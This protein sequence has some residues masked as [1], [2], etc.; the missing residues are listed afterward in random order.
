MDDKH[1]E[2][3]TRKAKKRSR[4]FNSRTF[5]GQSDSLSLPFARVSGE[6][7][8][9]R[10]IDLGRNPRLL[11]SIREI[12]G[13]PSGL[14]YTY[15]FAVTG[16]TIIVIENQCNFVTTPAQS[17][18]FADIIGSSGFCNALVNLKTR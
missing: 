2:M 9:S 11:N 13:N 17:K 16:S 4:C 7:R 6:I 8:V 15:L 18:L 12:F 1:A 3:N 5:L 14:R 10:G